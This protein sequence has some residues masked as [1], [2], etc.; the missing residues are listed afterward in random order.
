MKKINIHYINS[1]YQNI[2]KVKAEDNYSINKDTIVNFVESNAATFANNYINTIF[3]MW[4]NSIGLTDQAN[5][6]KPYIYNTK[7]IDHIL[8]DDFLNYVITENDRLFLI[9]FY[10]VFYNIDFSAITDTTIKSRYDK[11][12]YF[13]SNFNF[14]TKTL[15][16]IKNLKTSYILY[17][18][19]LVKHA[20]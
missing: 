18:K 5:L 1:F 2:N 4:A 3:Y 10:L 12:H 13:A 7:L 14:D 15:E 6:I 11:I 8:D 16:E 20:L 17:N 19:V 9:Y